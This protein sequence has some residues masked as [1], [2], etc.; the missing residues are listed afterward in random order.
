M[1]ILIALKTGMRLGEIIGLQWTDLDLVRGRL[2]VNRTIWRGHPNS[3]KG[4]RTRIIDLPRSVVDA[5]KAARHLKG[6]W[7][8]AQA[9]GSLMT[10]GMLKWPLTRALR[11]SGI[12]RPQGVIGWHD[13][14]HTTAATWRCAACR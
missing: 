7:V 5:L 11:L 4:G 6:P 10:P 8:F 2:N 9:D 3:P 12:S 13:L 1:S 14:R